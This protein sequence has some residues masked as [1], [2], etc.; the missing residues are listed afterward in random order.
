MCEESR[1][2]CSAIF[3]LLLVLIDAI[4]WFINDNNKKPSAPGPDRPVMIIFS[5]L[6]LTSFSEWVGYD[7]YMRCSDVICL[8]LNICW[9]SSSVAQWAEPII[10][11]VWVGPSHLADLPSTRSGWVFL[12]SCSSPSVSWPAP[13]SSSGEG[14]VL[15]SI[16]ATLSSC[17]TAVPRIIPWSRGK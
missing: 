5:F 14:R 8:N 15:S 17:L 2:N 12:L 4:G 9:G 13:P 16:W 3:V 6:L 7:L 10:G 1:G 11:S